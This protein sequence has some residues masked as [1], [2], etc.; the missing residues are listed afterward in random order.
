MKKRGVGA[1]LCRVLERSVDLLVL[2]TT[3]L[4][5]LSVTRA[6]VDQMLD[7]GAVDAL[8]RFVPE[9][10]GQDVLLF[11]A[12]RALFN[13][14]FD[15]SARRRMVE[16]NL[17]PKLVDVLPNP[18]VRDVTVALLYHL[19][20]D[21]RCKAMLAETDA[22]RFIARLLLETDDL[23]GAPE[24]IALA[25]NLTHDPGAC[26]AMCDVVVGD[27]LGAGA[28]GRASFTTTLTFF[29]AF[30]DRALKRR[31]ALA[32]KLLRNVSTHGASSRARF[33]PHLDRVVACLKSEEPGS[34]AFVELLG[35]LGN[36]HCPEA[37]DGLDLGEFVISRGLLEFAAIVLSPGESDDDVALEAVA[38]VGSVVSETTAAHVVD[39]GLVESAYA[40]LREKKDDDEFVLQIVRAFR[41]MLRHPETRDALLENTQAAYYLV[42]L[43]A[44]ECESVA[45][46][47][48]FALDQVMDVSEEWAVTIRRLKFEAHN[49]EWLDAA[50]AEEE[51]GALFA[52]EAH[53]RREAKRAGGG[54][55]AY[56]LDDARGREGARGGAY[57]HSEEEEGGEEEVGGGVGEGEREGA[58]WRAAGSST[59]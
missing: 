43:L 56:R 38:F 51:R 8:A 11:V 53:A 26:D 49:A 16:R 46:A 27:D 21:D 37:P 3:F 45:R 10:A 32:L 31:D 54:Q 28:G 2:A 58:A 23:E 19:S 5:K 4:K 25:V 55:R 20:A 33:A 52:E 29:D 44:D 47:A 24:L 9:G 15:T 17:I 13:L 48:D 22:P 1:Y 41:A 34:D 59:A 50:A 40:L 14:S 57:Y 36:L 42:D 6:N 39:A 7:A 30:V 18:N 35:T 12:L